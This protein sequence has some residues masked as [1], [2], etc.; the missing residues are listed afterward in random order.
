M[1]ATQ[2]HTLRVF[3]KD[4]S[5]RSNDKR[6]WIAP[7]AMWRAVLRGRWVGRYDGEGIVEDDLIIGLAIKTDTAGSDVK[8]VEMHDDTLG[9]SGIGEIIVGSQAYPITYIEARRCHGRCLSIAD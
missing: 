5:K 4:Y 7:G 6:P 1:L 2:P 9:A 8:A 3:S